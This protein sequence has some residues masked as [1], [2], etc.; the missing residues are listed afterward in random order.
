[1]SVSRKGRRVAVAVI[2]EM[3][4]IPILVGQEIEGGGWMDHLK[5]ELNNQKVTW[6]KAIILIT[7]IP[8]SDVHWLDVEKNL[9]NVIGT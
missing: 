3:G 9:V 7:I 8:R 5:N 1:M 6:N 4:A 2:R